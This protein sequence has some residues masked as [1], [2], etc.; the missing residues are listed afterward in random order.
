M[1]VALNIV[2]S[3]L[4]ADSIAKHLERD[5]YVVI[6]RLAAATVTRAVLELEADI[7][8]TDHG[9]T[10]FEGEHVRN[11]EGL[12]GRSTAACELMTHP[13]VLEIADCVLLP[14][15]ARYQLNWTSCRHL[16]PG[17]KMQYLHRDGQI[18]PFKNPHP[19]TQLA[20]MWAGTD[21]TTDNGATLV[22]PGSHLWEESRD[23]RE[24]EVL[25]TE[26]PL[27]SVLLYTSGTLH[28]GGANTT[29]LAR[30]GIAIQYSLGWLRQEE[31]LHLAVP[32]SI[33]RG[34]PETLQ[35]L[36]GYEF[37]APY[38]GF[39]NGDHPA[40]LIGR[41]AEQLPSYTTPEIDEAAANLTLLRLGDMKPVATKPSDAPTVQTMKGPIQDEID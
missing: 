21:F 20:T 16:E 7:G 5:G 37:G 13:L 6:D 11:V 38:L 15:C 17:A 41:R 28:G 3:D 22:V 26:M 14:Y 35:D 33:A 29:A 2:P 23:A 1:T 12:I 24:S 19:P 31:N 9:N 30:T 25:K 18:Y 8:A 4:S 36:I 32:P 40:K 39:V 10:Y 34:L 27:G